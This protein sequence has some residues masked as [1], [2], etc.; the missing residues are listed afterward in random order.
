MDKRMT[1]RIFGC[2]SSSLCQSSRCD[3]EWGLSS[4]LEWLLQHRLYWH[5][6]DVAGSKEHLTY[7]QI[8]LTFQRLIRYIVWNFQ[9]KWFT[10]LRDVQENTV[11][12]FLPKT[13]HWC[14]MYVC[15]G[16][17]RWLRCCRRLSCCSPYVG[18]RYKRTTSS[19][20]SLSKS[21]SEC[22]LFVVHWLPLAV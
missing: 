4:C 6:R 8:V 16:A 13:L 14:G 9:S 21:T 22:I 7:C 15:V 3:L 10:F 12:S 20:K 2:L 17:C 1:W 19:L 18:C 11:S 5:P